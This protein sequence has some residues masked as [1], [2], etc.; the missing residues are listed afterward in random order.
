VALSVASWDVTALDTTTT[1][2]TIAS[3]SWSSG[4]IIVIVGVVGNDQA[5]LPVPTNAN[6]TFTQATATAGGGGSEGRFYIWTATAGSSQTGQ[7]IQ[8]T[9]TVFTE[10]WGFAVW[11]VAGSSAGT[12][13]A[14]SNRTEAAISRTVSAGSLVIYAFDDWNAAVT[15]Q[16]ITTG[17]GTATER[18]DSNASGHGWYFG[19]WLGVSA[20]TFS[21]GVT[22]YTG[23]TVSHGCIEVLASAATAPDAPT[24][25]VGTPGDT[26][27]TV[28]WTLGADGG[29]AIT[30]HDI[31]WALASAPTSWL[32][33]ESG[34]TAANHLKTGLVNGTGYVFRVRAVNA[35]GNGAWSASSATVTPVAAGPV[36]LRSPIRSAL[37]L[38]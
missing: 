32:G 28:E 6:L 30:D 22:S 36:A 35:V 15:D 4:D 24:A 19:D 9:R 25:V 8:G 16:T 1:P 18:A 11:V 29:S 14:T 33:P 12:T 2:K 7:T 38:A 5:T 26:Q 10:Q 3:L 13:N 21:F 27:I 23:L 37:R 34:T 20:G 31:D 17:S